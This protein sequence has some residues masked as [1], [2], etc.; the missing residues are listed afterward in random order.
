[1]QI[2]NTNYAHYS[3]AEK[4]FIQKIVELLEPRT[5]DSHRYRINNPKTLLKELC[6]VLRDF[7][8][9]K[10]QHEEHVDKVIKELFEFIK[11][12]QDTF[13][14]FN[15]V[16]QTYF[17]KLLEKPKKEDFKNLSFVIKKLLQ[18]NENYFEILSTRISAEIAQLNSSSDINLSAL[19]KLDKMITYLVTEI[20]DRGFAKKV[21]RDEIW[22]IFV[23][24]NCTFV[25][26]HQ[27]LRTKVENT[28]LE[29][30]F[31]IIYRL[32]IPQKLNKPAIQGARSET[33]ETILALTN[34][35]ITR[36][37]VKPDNTFISFEE[38]G[39]DYM[40]VLNKSKR[41]LAEILDI[42]YLG[43]NHANIKLHDYTLVINL[44]RPEQ[45][46]AHPIFYQTE[47]YYR[48]G[49]SIYTD[50]NNKLNQIYTSSNIN[51]EAKEKIKSGV[52]Y[53][54]MG[55]EAIELEQ[56]FVNYWLGLEYIFSTYGK[57]TFS[58][59][60]KHFSNAHLL[61]YVKRNFI[62]FHNDIVRLNLGTTIP[63]FDINNPIA[64]LK[65]KETYTN[66]IEQHKA[67]F[68]LL[69]LRAELY[70]TLFREKELNQLIDNHYHNL[71]WNLGRIYRI[72]NEIVHDAAIDIN[73][74]HITTHLRYYLSFIL[75]NLLDF[76]TTQQAISSHNL[77]IED[78]FIL[79][80]VLYDDVRN[81]TKPKLLDFLEVN[82]NLENENV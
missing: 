1:M 60:L 56:K 32:Q 57:S 43:Y 7:E 47:G 80:E 41:K 3:I 34:T 73:I 79:N 71:Q 8:L 59:I 64:Y 69:A 45:A 19:K 15:F 55:S 20:L 16:K 70:S 66:I 46:K 49:E 72:R 77:S 38:N 21:V 76:F 35:S 18:E 14:S 44:Q 81:G 68:P 63:N 82:T 61:V 11:D 6:A 48:S 13:L 54:R 36:A 12:N 58:R 37:F 5:L 78:Y 33:K 53:L 65:I 25:E 52:R 67:N 10:I 75:N 30:R 29:E 9:R 51:I 50:F 23:K 2:I 28:H 74:E 17:T 24:S 62:E 27:I 42:L 22:E 40:Q 26:A 39:L 4:F 31:K